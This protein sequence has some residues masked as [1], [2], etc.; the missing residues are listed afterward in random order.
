MPTTIRDAILA[1]KLAASKNRAVAVRALKKQ[2]SRERRRRR[3]ANRRE[4]HKAAQAVRTTTQAPSASQVLRGSLIAWL[5]MHDLRLVPIIEQAVTIKDEKII[6]TF[7]ENIPKTLR[8][9]RGIRKIA[10]RCGFK[11]VLISEGRAA[12]FTA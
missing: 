5:S 10:K 8:N 3:R 1:E 2:E 4:A 9:L 12:R 7:G 6:L 11:M